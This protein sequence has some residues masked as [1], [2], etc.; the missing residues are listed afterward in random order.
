MNNQLLTILQ[1]PEEWKSIY[2]IRKKFKAYKPDP[3]S[4]DDLSDEL[5]DIEFCYASLSKVSRSFSV[6]IRLLP[7]ELRDAVCLFYL[8]LRGL[9]SIEDDTSINKEVRIKLLSNFHKYIFDP[10]WSL[11]GIGTNSD[12]RMLLENFQ[13]VNR[14][15]LQ[16][17]SKYQDVI[18]RICKEMGEGMILYLDRELENTSEYNEYCYYV[19][20]LVGIG[21]TELF[22]LSGLEDERL[23]NRPELQVAM[24]QFLQKTNIIRDIKEDL[25]ESRTFWPRQIWGKYMENID[26]YK[27]SN[28]DEAIY[29]LNHMVVDA[30]DLAPHC[31]EYLR[32]INN[33][34]ILQFCAIPQ[35]MAI[36]TLAEVFHNPDVF[37]RNVKIRKG[38]A[39]AI[40]EKTT[41]FRTALNVYHDMAESMFDKISLY[42]PNVEYHVRN[43]QK[44]LSVKES[45]TVYRNPKEHVGIQGNARNI[46]IKPVLNLKAQ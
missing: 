20:G 26:D 14:S 17:E 15:F 30:L 28:S 23:L 42:D 46:D 5:T 32:M 44:I 34:G 31:L 22:T 4:L 2:K 38:L 3:R 35:V 12:Y 41:D 29:G 11:S 7:G 27:D 37:K 21:L 1:H 24:G 13:K 43:L 33:P 25:D 8:V 16:L 19:A 9:D 10:N 6:V 40:F 18:S 36:A 45:F 39:A